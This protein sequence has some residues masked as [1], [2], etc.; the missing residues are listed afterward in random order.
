MSASIDPQLQM[1]AVRK[2]VLTFMVGAHASGDA[3][4]NQWICVQLL[5]DIHASSCGCKRHVLFAFTVGGTSP[6]RFTLVV[7]YVL[8]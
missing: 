2:L 7:L 6:L 5:A 4:H 8:F 1:D 3:A